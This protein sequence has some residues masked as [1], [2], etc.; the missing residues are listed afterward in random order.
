LTE[1]TENPR[2]ALRV[3][4]VDWQHHR[5]P[6]AMLEAG[7]TVFGFSARSGVFGVFIPAAPGDSS[8]LFFK[9]LSEP[10]I[11]VDLV[12]ICRPADELSTIVTTLVQPLGA[13]T[14]WLEVPSS[15]ADARDVTTA[16]GI[17]LIEGGDLIEVARRCD[18]ER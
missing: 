11:T 17:A 15:A 7:F 13:R 16:A 18:L 8:Y 6:G 4:L 3:L 14:L 2:S 9:R 10:L 1:R 12:A 5:V